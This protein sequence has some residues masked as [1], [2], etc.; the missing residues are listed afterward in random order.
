V[1]YIREADFKAA[2]VEAAELCGWAVYSIPDSRRVYPRATAPGFPDLVL[3]RPPEIIFVEVKTSIGK[4]TVAQ[5]RWQEMLSK[6]TKV[7]SRVWRP[8]NWEEI[9]SRLSNGAGG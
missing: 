2:I 7:S 9:E 5:E 3:V 1:Q 8:G 6:C 4:L